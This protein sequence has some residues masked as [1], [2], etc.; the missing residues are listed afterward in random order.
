MNLES[1]FRKVGA[2]LAAGTVITS[3]IMIASIL[4]FFR[5]HGTAQENATRMAANRELQK[6]FGEFYPSGG[7][8]RE[9]QAVSTGS[10]SSNGVS[11][12]RA[13]SGGTGP[14]VHTATFVDSTYASSAVTSSN[15]A[16]SSSSAPPERQVSHAWNSSSVSG[17]PQVN[18]PVTINV[19]NGEL[20]SELKQVR[21]EV[22]H[23]QASQQALHHATSQV[24]A[25]A[26][27]RTFF[28]EVHDGRSAS[29]ANGKAVDATH[30][31][32]LPQSD[33]CVI[34]AAASEDSLTEPPARPQT[35]IPNPAVSKL[36]TTVAK[37]RP[38]GRVVAVNYQ[39]QEEVHFES[40]ERFG[41]RDPDPHSVVNLT[42]E[43]PEL[44]PTL[45]FQAFAEAERL[46]PAKPEFTDDV[47][48]FSLLEPVETPA[49]EVP[50][51]KE[52]PAP[53]DGIS[54]ASSRRERLSSAFESVRGRPPEDLFRNDEDKGSN[55][56]G[57]MSTTATAVARETVRQGETSLPD[58]Q[59]S[60]G[61][62]LPG[63]FSDK[64]STSS[65]AAAETNNSS[66]F[67]ADTGRRT[68][69]LA[70]EVRPGPDFKPSDRH[71]SSVGDTALPELQI[72]SLHQEVGFEDEGN[73]NLFSLERVEVS[74]NQESNIPQDPARA[75]QLRVPGHLKEGVQPKPAPPAELAETPMPLPSPRAPESVP[76]QSGSETPGLPEMHFA[77]EMYALPEAYSGAQSQEIACD[78]QCPP[79]GLGF[80]KGIHEPGTSL[81]VRRLKKQ[82]A[83]VTGDMHLPKISFPQLDRPDFMTTPQIPHFALPDIHRPQFASPFATRS[84]QPTRPPHPAPGHPTP[85]CSEPQL[86]RPAYFAPPISMPH[87]TI[88]QFAIPEFM[89]PQTEC[90][91]CAC[92][93]S[94]TAPTAL[95]ILSE[96]QTL[97]RA[98]SVM[99]FTGRTKTV[100]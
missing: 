52:I 84:H 98:R 49:F 55:G 4:A 37:A 65:V 76:P 91:C 24:R 63:Y 79:A 72:P 33:G 11:S 30:R 19:N 81:I 82:I 89:R 14:N 31:A 69:A 61:L 20:L 44:L 15:V 5:D 57:S 50:L 17:V 96:S 42:L 45:S 68:R 41:P 60:A 85:G 36:Q 22:S 18:V 74:F 71:Y 97:R 62:I 88:P 75:G 95:Q 93:D 80:S 2:L 99:R 40:I 78:S 7:E 70:P 86:A 34:R 39:P 90:R 64:N 10:T 92:D 23:L 46:Q 53:T 29:G 73:P 16:S 66:G 28:Y 9:S 58:R 56:S 26:Q 6:Y 43:S 38:S 35:S 59:R 48:E 100:Q 51:L 67:E 47:P 32:P 8:P 54:A 77:P 12:G 87:F 3:M 25:V 94:A 1:P 27:E 83:R 21:Q 13:A